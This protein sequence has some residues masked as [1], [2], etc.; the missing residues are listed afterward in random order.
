MLFPRPGMQ[1]TPE[2]ADNCSAARNAAKIE[3]LPGVSNSSH[4]D[5]NLDA[6]ESWM[7]R[8]W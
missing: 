4:E 3:E 7:N 6:L 2:P 5:G 8:K 1:G